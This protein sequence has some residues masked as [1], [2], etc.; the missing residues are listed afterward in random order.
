MAVMRAVGY[1]P[2]PP[3]ARVRATEAQYIVELDVADFTVDELV[4][5]MLGPVVF[6]RGEQLETEADEGLPFRI[7]E[8]LEETFRLPDDVELET[9]VATYHHGVLE[10]R[11]DHAPLVLREIAIEQPPGPLLNPDAAAV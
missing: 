10:I 2:L 5:E 4:I 1:H 7:R 8:R 9:V 6:V 11:V 3:H